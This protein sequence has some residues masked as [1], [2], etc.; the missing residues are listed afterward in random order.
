[1]SKTKITLKLLLMENFMNSNQR[2]GPP[3]PREG[4]ITKQNLFSVAIIIIIVK[5]NKKTNQSLN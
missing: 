3:F 5:A 2:E 4:G 1:M